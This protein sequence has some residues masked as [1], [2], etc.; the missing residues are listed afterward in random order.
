MTK[1][2]ITKFALA[3][4][5]LALAA[6]VAGTTTFADEGDETG[7]S[8]DPSTTETTEAAPSDSSVYFTKTL[9]TP[10]TDLAAI[11]ELTFSFTFKDGTF[12]PYDAEGVSDT[13]DDSVTVPDLAEQSITFT[14]DDMT[15]GDVADGVSTLTKQSNSVIAGIE[16]PKAGM[17]EYT[18]AETPDT[19]IG[20]A[21]GQKVEYDGTTYT[22]RVWVTNSTTNP[23]T[24]ESTGT[25][26]DPDGNKVNPGPGETTDPTDPTIV[27]TPTDSNTFNFENTYTVNATDKPVDPSDPTTAPFWVSKTVTGDMGD[28]TL[29]FDFTITIAENKLTEGKTFTLTTPNGD[30]EVTP[31]KAAT[32]QLKHGEYA[33]FK[34]ITAGADVTVTEA[35]T[36]DYD[37]A[38]SAIFN[39]AT[40]VAGTYDANGLLGTKTNSA[41]YTNN[42]KGGDVTPTGILMNNL[43][44]V[45][46][47]VVGGI[48]L[49]FYFM[50][51]RRHA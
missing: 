3:A 21:D 29:P 18:V 23:G 51:K 49:G 5:T 33:Y 45:A 15:K 22:L 8:T 9:N 34:E 43:P 44:Y 28:I 24:T 31:G 17:Y 10:S 32:F 46:L 35:D 1:T 27:K 41:A 12:Y 42:H 14:N 40:A 47:I 39:G 6:G 36:T 48:G 4:G 19:V 38:N 30:V 11:P 20:L 2:W 25:V 37:E 50:N 16:F 26:E 13:A 7:T